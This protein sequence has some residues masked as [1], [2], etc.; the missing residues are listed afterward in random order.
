[1]PYKLFAL[2]FCLFV[3]PFAWADSDILF[4]PDARFIFP[5]SAGPVFL[6]Q[7]SRSTP[8]NVSSFW[9]P[10]MAQIEEL[11]TRLTAYL[12]VRVKSGESMP[13]GSIAYHRQYIGIITDGARRI[14]GNF[15]P[16]REDFLSEEA[17][18]PIIVCDGGPAFWGT[19][20][21]S[22]RKPSCSPISMGCFHSRK[23]SVLVAIRTNTWYYH[24]KTKGGG[25][26]V[27]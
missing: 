16:G 2:L 9:E 17:T 10:T 12:S 18:M 3:A 24:G 25:G 1:M 13:I 27:F 26:W 4:P 15:Y 19:H 21:T 22:K 23:F 5:A 7:C 6:K 8:A 11:E 20:T 14:Y